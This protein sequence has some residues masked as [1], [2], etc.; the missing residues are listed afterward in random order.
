MN[1]VTNRLTVMSSRQRWVF[2]ALV[3]LFLLLLFGSGFIGS[4]VQ[5]VGVVAWG[6]GVYRCWQ[7]HWG[8]GVLAFLV[9]PIGLFIGIFTFMLQR[10]IPAEFVAW[11]RRAKR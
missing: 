6:Y 1:V 3:G 10:D 8:L 11:L 9:F 5:V 2:A 7:T 4:L